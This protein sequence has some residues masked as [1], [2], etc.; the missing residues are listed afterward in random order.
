[1]LNSLKIKFEIP[2]ISPEKVL[3]VL[4]SMPANKATG[5]DALSPNENFCS[6]HIKLS[7]TFHKPLP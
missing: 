7:R 2:H 3:Q 4:N 1:M 6:I 5:A